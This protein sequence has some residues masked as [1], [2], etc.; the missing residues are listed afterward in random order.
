MGATYASPRNGPSVGP[1]IRK[2]VGVDAISTVSIASLRR[3]DPALRPSTPVLAG[4]HAFLANT[5]IGGRLPFAT[6]L[7]DGED[8]AGVVTVGRLVTLLSVTVDVVGRPTL[9]CCPCVP[10]TRPAKAPPPSSDPAPPIG[11]LVGLGRPGAGRRK[12][13]PTPTIRPVRGSTPR[14][15]AHL[16][17]TPTGGLETSDKGPFKG[18]VGLVW[19]S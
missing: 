9:P 13:D 4:H 17:E 12:A 15:T 19:P 6:L 18:V 16:L 11:V 10:R 8:V 7:A 14:P 1:Q 3:Q 5:M 2:V